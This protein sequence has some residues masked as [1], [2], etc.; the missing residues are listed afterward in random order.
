[1]PKQLLLQN[2]FVKT[3]CVFKEGTGVMPAPS[4]FNESQVSEA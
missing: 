3:L 4:F 1:M 2:K